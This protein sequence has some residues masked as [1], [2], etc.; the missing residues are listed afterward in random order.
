MIARDGRRPQPPILYGIA[1]ADAVAPRSLADAVVAMA[2][3]GVRWIQIRAKS[4]STRDLYLEVEASCRRVEGSG[5]DL[6]ID[7]RAD[8]AALF[9]VAGVQVGQ[10]DLPPRAVREVVGEGTWIGLSTHGLAQ[11]L[12]ADA[13]PAVDL[14]AIGPVFATRSK[15]QPDPVVGLETVALVRRAVVKPLVAIG[16]IDASNAVSVLAAGADSV[17][18]IGAL[19]AGDS[20]ARNARRLAAVLARTE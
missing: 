18:V 2:D 7:D 14:I 10:R 20:I 9:P 13:C 1:D 19:C 11:A 4:L 12:A 6:W 3:A 8:L 16:G 17:A 15:V 5:V